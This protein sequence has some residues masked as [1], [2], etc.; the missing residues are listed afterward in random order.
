MRCSGQCAHLVTV[1]GDAG[2]G[3]SRLV[4]EVV[5]QIAA[6][7]RALRGRCLPYGDG[8]TFWPLVGMVREAADI[9][10]DDPRTRRA[11]SS[12][13][14]VK[15]AEVA[16]RL[17]SAIGPERAELP[18]ARAVLGARASSSRAWPPTTRWSR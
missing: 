13:Q 17:A 2:L 15:D 4:R 16:A 14:T 18:A 3:K 1:I 7:A 6:G 8:I 9:R 10:D 12:L 11:P 5:D